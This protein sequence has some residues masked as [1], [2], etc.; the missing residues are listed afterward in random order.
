MPVQRATCL[1]HPKREAAAQ[2]TSCGKPFCRE[3]V[4]EL[5]GRMVCGPCYR[6]Q[7]QRVEKPQRDWFAVTTTLQALAGAGVLWFTSWVVG[8]A[9]LNI[10]S[11][12]HEGIVWES[13]TNAFSGGGK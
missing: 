13:V 1:N 5:D 11:S 9:L 10:K 3:C 7:V 2:C 8:Q 4:T 6:K 12:F